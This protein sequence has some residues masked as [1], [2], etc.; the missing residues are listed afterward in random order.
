[1]I[2][3]LPSSTVLAQSTDLYP[4]RD[5]SML[6]GPV[7]PN[8][9]GDEEERGHDD[10]QEKDHDGKHESAKAAEGRN[11]AAEVIRHALLQAK[12]ALSPAERSPLVLD[13]RRSS[14]TQAMKRRTIASCCYSLR[15]F[16]MMLLALLQV[17]TAAAA[18]PAATVATT[19]QDKDSASVLH[20]RLVL[21]NALQKQQKQASHTSRDFVSCQPVE[22]G[23]TLPYTYSFTE[24]KDEDAPLIEILKS[25]KPRLARGKLLFLK[26]SNGRIAENKVV[27]AK[28]ASLELFHEDE[29]ASSS[30]IRHDHRHLLGAPPNSGTLTAIV[31]R[32]IANDAQPTPTSDEMHY[33]VFDSSMSLR[34]Q[35]L[36]CSAGKLNIAPT[37]FGVLDA[38]VNL[39]ANGRNYLDLVNEAYD[40]ALPVVQ[41]SDSSITDVRNLSD[42]IMFVL[43]PGTI[44]T[45][46]GR[47][48]F[49]WAA[50]GTIPGQQTVFNDV[51]ATYMGGMAHEVGHNFGLMH[52]WEGGMDYG[53]TTGFMGSATEK[54]DFPQRCYNA[55]NH[56]QLG[57]YDDRLLQ[58]DTGV[59]NLYQVA[60]FVD[61]KLTNPSQYVVLEIVSMGL[62]LQY[63]RA[64]SY[65]SDTGEHPDTL[66]IVQKTSS[67]TNLVASLTENDNPFVANGVVIVVCSVSSD[68]TGSTADVLIVGI[69]PDSS[70]C[71]LLYAASSRSDN[72]VVAATASPTTRRPTYSPTTSRVATSFPTASSTMSIETSSPTAST[73]IASSSSAAITEGPTIEPSIDVATSSPTRPIEES[74][75]KNNSHVDDDDNGNDDDQNSLTQGNAFEYNTVMN[76]HNDSNFAVDKSPSNSHS[77]KPHKNIVMILFITC[78]SL[79]TLTYMH[80]LWWAQEMEYRA[81]R[82]MDGFFKPK[83]QRSPNTEQTNA[84]RSASFSSDSSNE[85]E[86]LMKPDTE[87]DAEVGPTYNDD[88]EMPSLPEHSFL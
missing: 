53:D 1:M 57:W 21:F 35:L 71:S 45:G 31:I 86:D 30:M 14:I 32:I 15:C 41:R 13:E 22:F 9:G 7:D 72:D 87:D 38:R 48:Q 50:F 84:S 25:A 62:Y 20:C 34:S 63:N 61:Y 44:S 76:R 36:R 54:V 58:V 43:P 5:D 73:T 47:A 26:I 79:V 59:S 24:D 75:S 82:E 16:A 39:S 18:S 2:T 69:G 51:W 83:R 33:Y 55:E 17:T 81:S 40:A 42:L 11:K 4:G 23:V 27:I 52:S 77:K 10:V 68:A 74:K 8:L 12:D 67:G 3:N 37:S 78:F 88:V 80:R 49:D 29:T 65:N 6:P 19:S 46:S 60:A 85:E 66:V 64:K 70:V 56:A 28:D